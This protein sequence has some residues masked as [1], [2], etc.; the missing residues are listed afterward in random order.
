VKNAGDRAG[1]LALS[2]FGT[3]RHHVP[4]EHAPALDG[5]GFHLC[6]DCDVSRSGQPV[7]TAA[8]KK[9]RK[10]SERQ[11]Q[12]RQRTTGKYL[13]VFSPLERMTLVDA[14]NL[15]TNAGGGIS[16]A[17]AA[18]SLSSQHFEGLMER[19]TKRGLF[20]SMTQKSSAMATDSKYRFPWFS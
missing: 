14:G 2:D 1:G 6:D 16:S 13:H 11:N 19:E 8:M 4:E 12:H 7:G 10:R 18:L 3:A 15:Q 5:T 17:G 9:S 20:T